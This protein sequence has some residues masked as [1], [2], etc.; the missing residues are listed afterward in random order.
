MNVYKINFI[1]WQMMS[2]SY[3]QSIHIESF[4][5][6]MFWITIFKGMDY[7]AQ[8]KKDSNNNRHIILKKKPFVA[9]FLSV[10]TIS[11]HS[12]RVGSHVSPSTAMIP[13]IVLRCCLISRFARLL[14]MM[15]IRRTAGSDLTRYVCFLNQETQSDSNVYMSHFSVLA[16]IEKGHCASWGEK[17]FLHAKL[18]FED[19]FARGIIF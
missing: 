16:R 13:Q 19:N 10:G 18:H 6:L 14:T 12:P 7:S 8:L 2:K 11:R 3:F 1:F 15:K 17:E 9:R 5:Q 4:F